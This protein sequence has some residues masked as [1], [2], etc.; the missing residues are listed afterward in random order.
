LGYAVKKERE[1]ANQLL[2]ASD[3]GKLSPDNKKIP[4]NYLKFMDE[5]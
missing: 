2:R 4:M 5:L 3:K 1:D